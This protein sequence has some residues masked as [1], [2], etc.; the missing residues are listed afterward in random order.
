MFQGEHMWLDSCLCTELKSWRLFEEKLSSLS[1]KL[2]SSLP[3]SSLLPCGTKSFK[4]SQFVRFR[5]TPQTLWNIC[6]FLFLFGFCDSALGRQRVPCVQVVSSMSPPLPLFTASVAFV[7]K[8][9]LICYFMFSKLRFNCSYV[10]I[11]W[12]AFSPVSG[13]ILSLFKM[14]HV[15]FYHLSYDTC[16]DVS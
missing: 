7:S 10:T 15:L 12:S 3:S 9:P 11:W 6:L 5:V 14:T 4:S 16:D 13:H 1:E 8:A 2:T